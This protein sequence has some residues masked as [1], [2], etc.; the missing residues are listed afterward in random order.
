MF[1]NMFDSEGSPA[2]PAGLLQL[3]LSR[4]SGS[5]G[6]PSIWES[7]VTNFR[8]APL[9]A[10]YRQLF[11]TVLSSRVNWYRRSKYLMISQRH[12][13]SS[14]LSLQNTIACLCCAL[15]FSDSE[16]PYLNSFYW[17]RKAWKRETRFT[18]DLT[19]VPKKC[20]GLVAFGSCPTQVA[21][22]WIKCHCLKKN[23]AQWITIVANCGSWTTTQGLKCVHQSINYKSS[24]QPTF[25][26]FS[27]PCW[28][29]GRL[30]IRGQSERLTQYTCTHTHRV[31]SYECHSWLAQL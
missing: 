29:T 15:C 14:W 6:L 4:D 8:H 26:L 1:S 13:I 30:R 21:A 28:H 2:M 3:F 12:L 18:W 31:K 7:C 20:S 25:F 5:V 9:R 23:Q 19:R 17:I 16:T 22:V 10:W 11:V 24:I 27:C